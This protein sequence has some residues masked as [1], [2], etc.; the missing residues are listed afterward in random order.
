MDVKGKKAIVIG[1]TSGIG[2]SV[3]RQL[4]DAAAR[5]IGRNLFDAS[6]GCGMAEAA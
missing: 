5:A 6:A 1:G 2:L 4:V 3:T